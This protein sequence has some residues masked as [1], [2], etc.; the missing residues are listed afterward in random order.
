MKHVDYVLIFG[1]CVLL[2]VFIYLVVISEYFKK[3]EHFSNEPVD[4]AALRNNA[5][6]HSNVNNLY[7]QVMEGFSMQ[8]EHFANKRS[9]K[10]REL[11]KGRESSKNRNEP[12][13]GK[14]DFVQ[15]KER[16]SA[17]GPMM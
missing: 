11:F 5:A 7:R 9:F 2:S 16:G 1:L 12:F 13:M 3:H 4:M 8:K 14:D 15:D 10:G 6:N 17:G